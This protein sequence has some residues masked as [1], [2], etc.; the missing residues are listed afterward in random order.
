MPSKAP[1]NSARCLMQPPRRKSYSSIWY[2]CRF[3]FVVVLWRCCNLPWQPRGVPCSFTWPHCRNSATKWLDAQVPMA[4][5]SGRLPAHNYN[6]SHWPQCTRREE[7]GHV[8]GIKLV[9][10]RRFWSLFR[11]S[12]V[13][14][15]LHALILRYKNTKLGAWTFSFNKATYQFIL[16][17]VCYLFFYKLR[18]YNA[19]V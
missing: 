12:K 15:F 8:T 6:F 17:N 18:G 11:R 19:Y 14:I 10:L 1:S 5:L 4:A 7:R 13:V 9:A 2:F 3:R 16:L